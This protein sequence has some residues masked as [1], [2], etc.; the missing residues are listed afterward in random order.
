MPTTFLNPLI[1][2]YYDIKIIRVFD[3]E[4]LLSFL[5]FFVLI[6]ITLTIAKC[7]MTFFCQSVNIFGESSQLIEIKIII[8]KELCNCLMLRMTRGVQFSSIC[9][10]R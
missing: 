6:N 5:F 8:S 1:I 7:L 4:D 9:P 3:L 10:G 2:A